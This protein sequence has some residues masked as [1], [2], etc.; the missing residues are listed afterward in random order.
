M[1]RQSTLAREVAYSGIGLHSG[2]EVKVRFLPAPADTGILFE[3]IDLPGRPRVPAQAA[4]VTQTMR[5]TTLEAGEAKVFTVEHILAAFS[6]LNLDNCLIEIDS[7]EPPVA[8]GSAL[9]FLELLA[10][11]GRCEQQ[12]LRSVYCIEEAFI[13]RDGNRFISILPYD[14]F[15]ITFTSVNPHKAIGIQFAD[16]KITKDLFW[17]EIAPARTIGFVHEIEV[18]QAQGLALGGS[19]ENA[20]VYDENGAVNVLRFSDELVRHKV[21]DV[22]GDLALAGPIKGHVV[23]VSSGHALNTKLSQLIAAARQGGCA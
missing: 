4:C 18:L 10:E 2:R 13:V 3:R 14:G 21:L 16:V 5:A 11:A 20:A 23:A 7:M 6:A 1:E 22:V 17:R 8:D 12:A 9:P 19:M 15:R